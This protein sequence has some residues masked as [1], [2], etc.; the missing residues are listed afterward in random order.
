MWTNCASWVDSNSHEAKI[1]LKDLKKACEE[2][3]VEIQEARDV[4]SSGISGNDKPCLAD[5]DNSDTCAM[6]PA[7]MRRIESWIKSMAEINVETSLLFEVD[8][9]GTEVES[10]LDLIRFAFDARLSPKKEL[11]AQ[12]ARNLLLKE[13]SMDAFGRPR[14]DS[15]SIRPIGLPNRKQPPP[16]D[17][18]P[19]HSQPSVVDGFWW[20]LRLPWLLP[21][22]A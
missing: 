12:Q 20:P 2:I 16:T 5:N 9:S 18:G 14:F 8:D 19:V 13:A 6:Y 22:T 11:Q 7:S 10:E 21:F 3:N 4:D 15:K 1:T 17:G